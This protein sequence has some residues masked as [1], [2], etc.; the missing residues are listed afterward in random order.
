MIHK[1]Y[2]YIR[3][4]A[5]PGD[6]PVLLYFYRYSLIAFSEFIFYPFPCFSQSSRLALLAGESPDMLSQT[7]FVMRPVRPRP[8]FAETLSRVTETPPYERFMSPTMEP[9]QIAVLAAFRKSHKP[10]A[11]EPLALKELEAAILAAIQKG[12]DEALALQKKEKLEADMAEASIQ[13]GRD[14][15]LALQKKEESEADTALPTDMVRGADERRK[16]KN[17]MRKRKRKK[18][19]MYHE[20][21]GK[22]NVMNGVKRKERSPG[23]DERRGKKNAMNGRKRKKCSPEADER[24]GRKNVM[25]ERKRKKLSD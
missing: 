7:P 11:A 17:E 14:E 25:A 5:G 15:A 21:R 9:I 18:W 8:P 16:K 6:Q 24:R 3:N 2:P 20:R 23:A 22:K 1:C 19:M 4:L 12:R 10:L 13:K